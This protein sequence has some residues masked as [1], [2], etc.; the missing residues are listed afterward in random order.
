[1][2]FG[3]SHEPL[4]KLLLADLSVSQCQDLHRSLSLT[5]S[6]HGDVTDD[7]RAA[8]LEAAGAVLEAARCYEQLSDEAESRLAFGH[9]AELRQRALS[10]DPARDRLGAERLRR[11]GQVL[12]WAG[13]PAAAAR[14]YARAL[15]FASP[16]E[17]FELR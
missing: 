6:R 14:V 2:A 5:S 4:R 10:L 16:A 8:H 11:L 9:A 7:E 13:Q 12:S 1:P 17:S 15:T 3:L